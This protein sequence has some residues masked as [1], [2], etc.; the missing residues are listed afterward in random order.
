M[1]WV[2]SK[3]PSPASMSLMTRQDSL[4][5]T[6]DSS[7]A[8]RYRSL[9]RRPGV[10]AHSCSSS[11]ALITIGSS[12][13]PA[14]PCVISSLLPTFF[15]SLSLPSNFSCA[16]PT[17]V[18]CSSE[19]PCVCTAPMSVF[20]CPLRQLHACLSVSLLP[21]Q[22][23]LHLYARCFQPSAGEERAHMHAR[24]HA[25]THARIQRLSPSSR[26]RKRNTVQVTSNLHVFQFTKSNI[27]VFQPAAFQPQC[28]AQPGH[29]CS[30]LLPRENRLTAHPSCYTTRPR[31][32]PT[33][34]M[35]PRALPTLPL[36]ERDYVA[37]ENQ[38]DRTPV[39]T[40]IRS[41]SS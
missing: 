19:C 9:I 39:R 40:L 6:F 37:D 24:I 41:K 16:V 3:C 20:P 28:S 29:Q 32:L 13:V 27:H 26:E 30:S 7:E 10:P 4:P 14:P 31:T 33:P 15:K 12:L 34:P 11:P 23:H 36:H 1:V 38:H 22:F 2:L 5:R 25:R 18:S 17:F 21:V 35:H 8:R